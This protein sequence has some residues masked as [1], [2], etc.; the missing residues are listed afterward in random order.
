MAY[1]GR[2]EAVRAT[3]IAVGDL[4]VHDKSCT[5]YLKV[6]AVRHTTTAVSLTF[7]TGHTVTFRPDEQLY[8]VVTQ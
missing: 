8:R 2:T 5:G 1:Q 6:T 3:D 4:G 7:E